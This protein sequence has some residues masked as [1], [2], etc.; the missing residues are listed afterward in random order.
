MLNLVTSIEETKAY[1]YIFAKGEASRPPGIHEE[2]FDGVMVH[3]C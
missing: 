1:Q 3:R 2:R